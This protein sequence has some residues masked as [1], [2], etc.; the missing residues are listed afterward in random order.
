MKKNFLLAYISFDGLGLFS[1]VEDYL[2]VSVPKCI[3]YCFYH[4]SFLFNWLSLFPS[5]FF[6]RGL[7]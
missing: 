1:F 3:V 7:G 6:V 5:C 4:S 2:V